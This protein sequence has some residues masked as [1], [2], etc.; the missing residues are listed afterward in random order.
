MSLICAAGRGADRGH[1]T[2]FAL[3]V[4]RDGGARPTCIAELLFRHYEPEAT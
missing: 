1:Q 4:E 3:R 2:T